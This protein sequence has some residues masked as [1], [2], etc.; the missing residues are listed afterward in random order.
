[1]NVSAAIETLRVPCGI[2]QT[3]F[4][5]EFDPEMET[6]WAWLAPIGTPCFSLSLLNDMC[7]QNGAFQA[8]RGTIAVDGTPHQARYYVIGSRIKSVFSFGGDLALFMLLI[9]SRERDALTYYAKRC[10]DVV[11]PLIHNHE[12]P[13]L[14]SISLI[15]G[16]ALG[17]G[18]ECALTSDVLIAEESAVM[19]TPEILFNLFPGMGAYTLLARRIG[20]RKTEEIISTG[21]TLTARELLELGVV[22]AVVPDGQGES[23]TYAWIKRARRHHNGLAAMYAARRSVWP[24]TREELDSITAIWVDAAL[25]LAER[26]IK[27]MRRIVTAQLKRMDG[28]ARLPTLADVEREMALN[29]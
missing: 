28:G 2:D 23:G 1:M 18:F 13:D 14:I 17:G 8:A 16:D 26:D 27:M 9:K 21:R 25:R 29:A 7:A 5:F 3:Q 22:D 11:H 20:P 4:P 15:Q 19:G 6:L 10:I 24:V 12:V